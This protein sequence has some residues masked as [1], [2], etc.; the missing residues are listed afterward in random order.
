MLPR[1][2]WAEM[3]TAEFRSADTARWIAVLPIAAVEQHGPHLPVLVDTAIAE[4]NIEA[5]RRILPAALP[6][7]FLPTVWMGKS[8]EHINFPGTITLS[9]ETQIRMLTEIGESIAR[10][11][12]KK[13]VIANS[14]GG[15][16]AAMDIVARDLRARHGMLAVQVSW[17]RLGAPDGLFPAGE[18]QHGIHGGEI[19]T[20]Q[21]LH[22]RPDLVQMDKARDF[23][24]AAVAMEQ[25]YS[26]LRA[27]SP[28]GFGWMSE[29]LSTAGAIGN[30]AA[31]SAESGRL[32]TAFTAEAFIALLADVDRFP[33]DKLGT[34][35]T[36]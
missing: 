32:A 11:G 7:T 26:H 34:G 10:A 30:A 29:D 31:A 16:V 23:V 21:M 22:F 3:T 24:S 6:V 36:V 35:T 4:G 28:V 8:N 17:H 27:I 2:L 1:Q 15:N 13:L 18:I 5:V 12:V 14:H 33:L 9:A 25:S 20:S 19:E